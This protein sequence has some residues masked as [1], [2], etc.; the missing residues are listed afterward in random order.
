MSRREQYRLLS[1]A[2]HVRAHDTDLD[3]VDARVDAVDER[4][5]D[6]LKALRRALMFAAISFV[7]GFPALAFSIIFAVSKLTGG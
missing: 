7:I 3:R 1:L 2:D 4:V 6:E 5:S